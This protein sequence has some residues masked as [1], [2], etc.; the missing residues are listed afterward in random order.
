MEAGTGKGQLRQRRGVAAGAGAEAEPPV[1]S[2]PDFPGAKAAEGSASAKLA[3]AAAS[4]DAPT[5][6][7]VEFL[8][9]YHRWI[10]LAIFLFA[11]FVRFYRLDCPSGVV[12]D[13]VRTA[14]WHGSPHPFFPSTN[15]DKLLEL[16][17]TATRLV[18]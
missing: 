6:A 12:F 18:S 3:S 2:P 9:R 16:I 11:A 1:A 4:V 15:V 7:P 5:A 14:V 10:P 8:D 13:E 17:C